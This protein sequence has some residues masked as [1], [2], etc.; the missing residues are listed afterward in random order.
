MGVAARLYFDA[1]RRR[2]LQILRHDRRTAAVEREGRGEHACVPDRHEL[3]DACFR[4]REKD[5]DRIAAAGGGT[6]FRMRGSWHAVPD[7]L[8]GGQ[9]LFDR[10]TRRTEASKCCFALRTAPGRTDMR[11]QNAVFHLPSARALEVNSGLRAQSAVVSALPT[12]GHSR[13]AATRSA[14]GPWSNGHLPVDTLSIA[15]PVPECAPTTARR[16][17]WIR[18]G[19]TKAHRRPKRFMPK[20]TRRRAAC[21]I[22]A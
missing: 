16:S 21:R 10:T 14:N 18:S 11:C 5:I 2:R 6:V 13:P 8:A 15:H 17:P 7:R 9:T 3:C 12:H 1:G 22:G 19:T 4:L 20:T